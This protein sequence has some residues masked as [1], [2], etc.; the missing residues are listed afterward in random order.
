MLRSLEERVSLLLHAPFTPATWSLGGLQTTRVSGQACSIVSLLLCMKHERLPAAHLG[1]YC[2]LWW[3]HARINLLN[4]LL[5]LIVPGRVQCRS[6]RYVLSL[7]FSLQSSAYMTC[8][9]SGSKCR[10]SRCRRACTSVPDMCRARV[11]TS[12]WRLALRLE[13][14]FRQDLTET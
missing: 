13:Q 3:Q 7:I 12:G 9:L 2:L 14:T 6:P 11:R 4:F 5:W 8:V 1:T 10:S